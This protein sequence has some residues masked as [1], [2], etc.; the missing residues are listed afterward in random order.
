MNRIPSR[1]FLFVFLLTAAALR[2]HA[3]MSDHYRYAEA[4][5][6]LGLTNYSGDVSEKVIDFREFQLGYGAFMR[7]HFTKNFSLKFHGY[8]GSISGDDANS[9]ALKARSLRFST[10]LLELALVGELHLFR[11]SRYSK[12][13]IHKLQ[14]SPYVYAGAG[15]TI[16][17]SET[18]YY[19]PADRRNE[20]L[21][22][23]VP[24]ENL[25]DRF[26]I[27]P[28]GAG[29]RFDIFEQFILGLE[30]GFRPVFSDDLDGIHLNGNPNRG[31]WYYYGGMTVSFVFAKTGKRF[32][33]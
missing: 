1:R 8:S 17:T 9:P 32:P 24:E 27:V 6:M 5:I 12:T 26:T 15:M 28:M 21:K 20:N 4:G 19:G 14:V 23:P 29:L 25:K 11:K 33:Y 10:S 30:G 18:E 31:D 13:G 2:G 22:V 7:Y 16:A 3:Q